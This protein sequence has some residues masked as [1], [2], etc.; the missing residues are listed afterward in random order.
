VI[1]FYL[2]WTLECLLRSL[3]SALDGVTAYTHQCEV[4]C[5]RATFIIDELQRLPATEQKEVGERG[6]LVLLHETLRAAAAFCSQFKGRHVLRRIL[7]YRGDAERFDEFNRRLGEVA[8][9]A[10]GAG[11]RHPSVGRFAGSHRA[12]LF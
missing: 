7:T 5:A 8:R 12:E 3:V 4:L 6:V 2:P 10:R 9:V 11:G 1:L